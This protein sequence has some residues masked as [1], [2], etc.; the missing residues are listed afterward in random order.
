MAYFINQPKISRKRIKNSYC[1][2]SCPCD[3]AGDGENKRVLSASVWG[4][5]GELP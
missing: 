3:D 2:E 4:D 5:V 1:E